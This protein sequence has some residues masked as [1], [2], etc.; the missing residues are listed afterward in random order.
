MS[1]AIIMTYINSSLLPFGLV[2]ESTNGV[3]FCSKYQAF[4]IQ[5]VKNLVFRN[6]WFDVPSISIKIQ[7]FWLK[8]WVFWWKY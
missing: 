2:K 8:Y 5:G 4:Q 3:K 6:F 1:W 7:G